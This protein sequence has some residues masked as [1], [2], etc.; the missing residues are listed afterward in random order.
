M[1]R[2][3]RRRFD[4]YRFLV[5]LADRTTKKFGKHEFC[6]DCFHDVGL[7]ETCRKI[8]RTLKGE[9]P[10]CGSRSGLGVTR[11]DLHDLVFKFFVEGTYSHGHGY[12]APALTMRGIDRPNDLAIRDETQRDLQMIC[13]VVEIR[14]GYN[15]PPMWRL[16]YTE[17]WDVDD[18]GEEITW[19][20]SDRGA[21]QAIGAAP[22]RKLS[23]G[24]K[25]FRIRLNLREREVNDPQQ[26]DSPPAD[27][28]R[29]YGRFDE[30]HLSIFYGG[31]NLDVCLHEIRLSNRDEV[32]AATCELVRDLKLLDITGDDCDTGR[33][34]FENP[35]YFFNSLIFSN[36]RHQECRFLARK[37]KEAG[38][39]GFIY[40]SYHSPV[41]HS[42]GRNIALFGLPIREEKLAIRSINNVFLKKINVEYLM[43]PILL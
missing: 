29:E 8:G 13:S 25:V 31:K 24:T 5:G 36:A 41:M 42:P 20:L 3:A 16:G 6:S 23:I 34:A 2:L 28:A 1:L 43:G 40:K 19:K 38:F 21:L 39:D 9:C 35:L 33:N 12:Y 18:T 22:E 14:L 32:T 7:A 17:H 4:L 27:L 26:F 15:G 11:D 30:P 37:I 10:R